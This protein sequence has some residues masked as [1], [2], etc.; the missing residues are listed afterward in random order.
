M[1][2]DSLPG[3]VVICHDG[4]KHVLASFFW[5]GGEGDHT[6]PDMTHVI[7]VLTFW[8][9][10]ADHSSLAILAGLN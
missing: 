8:K 5:W 4:N 6:K 3:K 9:G 7:R 2:I 1:R 10:R